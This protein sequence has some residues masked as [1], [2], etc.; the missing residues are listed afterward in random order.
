MEHGIELELVKMTRSI[1]F[2]FNSDLTRVNILKWTGLF[3]NI[4]EGLTQIGHNLWLINYDIYCSK[5]VGSQLST[6][7][8]LLDSP[9]S[10]IC[11]FKSVHSQ[12]IIC[13]VRGLFNMFQC[14]LWIKPYKSLSLSDFRQFISPRL[15]SGSGSVPSMAP[16]FKN[17]TIEWKVIVRR[18]ILSRWIVMDAPR[19]E[20]ME[21]QSSFFNKPQFGSLEECRNR[22]FE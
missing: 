12:K 11:S 7:N 15:R 14:E 21:I 9:D 18:L 22:S 20:E 4:L 16:G 19:S 8:Y 3:S 17:W 2:R 10:G 5:L 6:W 13:F 1:I